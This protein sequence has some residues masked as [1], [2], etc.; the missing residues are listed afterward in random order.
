MSVRVLLVALTPDD[1]QRALGVIAALGLEAG[2]PD[3]SPG[4]D[5]VVLFD[6]VRIGPG[7]AA[8]FLGSDAATY[9]PEERTADETPPWRIAWGDATTCAFPWDDCA[10]MPCAPEV[11]AA[12]SATSA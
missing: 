3:A 6:A 11:L 2:A 10:P 4:P 1:T 12:R 8:L 9:G 5:D 7:E